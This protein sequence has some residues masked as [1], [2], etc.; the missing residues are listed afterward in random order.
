MMSETQIDGTLQVYNTL[1]RKKEDFEPLEKGKVRMYNCGPTVYNYFHVGNA[2]NFVV[3]DMIRR[4]LKYAGYDVTFVQNIT[5]IEDKIIKRAKEEN[6]TPEEIAEKYTKIFFESAG[7]LGVQEADSHP[8]ATQYVGKMIGLVKKLEDKGYAYEKDGDVYFRVANFDGYGKLSG[9]KIEDMLSGARVEVSEKKEHP[10]DFTL[11][12]AAKPDEPSWKSPWG[13]GRPGWHLE[14]SVMSMDILG[15]SFDIHMGGI[16]LTFP[17]HE[18]EIAQ[19]EAAT[20]KPFAKYWLH[21][22]FLNVNGEKMSKSL[23]NFFTID[24]VLEKYEPAVVRYFLLSGHY[25]APLDFSDQAL[26]EARTALNRLRDAYKAARQMAGDLKAEGDSVATAAIRDSFEDA[27][28]D[29]FNTPRA[30]AALFRASGHIGQLQK[31]LLDAEQAGEKDL[32]EKDKVEA[33]HQAA[34][35]HEL[36]EEILGIDLEA[37]EAGMEDVSGQLLDL[38]IRIRAAARKEKQFSL[39]DQVRDGLKEIGFE[40]LDRPGGVTEWKKT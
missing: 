33:A 29:D 6:C 11:W 32:E 30:L 14:C 27:M 22:G 34:I 7:R 21:N 36:G 38:L 12:K 40:L 2:R 4:Y 31:K 15:E 28:N 10:A 3:A 17:H 18:N 39:A 25:R 8:R 19:S 1:S 20:G 9:R 26:D 13:E 35:L 37:Q 5:D 23:G 16:D 24:E